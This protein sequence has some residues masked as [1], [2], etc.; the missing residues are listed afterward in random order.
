MRFYEFAPTA[1]R[2]DDNDD[3]FNDDTLKMLAAQWFNGNEDPKVEQILM[4]AGWE[5]G[6]DEGYDDEPG[7]FVVRAGDVH[8]DSYMSWSSEDL[9]GVSEAQE[10]NEL[11]FMGL[12]QC[13]KDCSG[14]EAGYA[15]SKARGG[16]NAAS[17]SPSFNKG[18]EIASLGY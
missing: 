13:T 8:G 1:D 3:G 7:V 15:W 18:A 11:T 16:R 6:Y 14:H 9:R 4:S 10:L 2:D 17:W 12:S 5:I